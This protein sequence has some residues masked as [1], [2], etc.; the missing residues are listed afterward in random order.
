M[1][2]LY[3][4]NLGDPTIYKIS[5]KRHRSNDLNPAYLWHCCLGHI[6][7]KRV[8]KLHRDGL[9]DSF[10]FESFDTCESCLLGKMTKS[11]V[12][13]TSE[14]VSDLLELVHSDVC[15]LM[16]SVA[17]GGFQYFITFTDDFSRYGYIYLI[18]HKSKSFEKF[19][20]FRMKYIIIPTR[21]LN[22]YDLIVEVNFEP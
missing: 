7:E 11:P 12:T 8:E 4:L 6:N 9:L 21:Q 5:T 22:F 2:G 13:G 16:S 10:D 1:N 18:R 20:S 15:G 19:R 17:R 3:I 14:R